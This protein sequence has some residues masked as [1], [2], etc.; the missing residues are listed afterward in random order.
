MGVR[1]DTNEKILGEVPAGATEVTIL[2]VGGIVA[3]QV[4]TFTQVN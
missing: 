1:A 4:V 3:D 2:S